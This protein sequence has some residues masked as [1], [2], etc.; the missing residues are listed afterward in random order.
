MIRSD[1]LNITKENQ[2]LQYLWKIHHH[3]WDISSYLHKWKHNNLLKR[4]FE[5][6]YFFRIFS[7]L[8]NTTS[9]LQLTNLFLI[10]FLYILHKLLTHCFHFVQP[11]IFL[12]CCLKT[13][14]WLALVNEQ[15]CLWIG[16]TS[17]C[18]LC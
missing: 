8:Y 12:I 6:L 3:H 7:Y 15:V 10:S 1:E 4:I 2:H 16:V 14:H 5:I 17:T 9:N 18:L 13:A 11:I